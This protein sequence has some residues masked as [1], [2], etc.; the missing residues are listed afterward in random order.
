MSN[1]QAAKVG[2]GLLVIKGTTVLLGKRRGSHGGGEYGGPGGH[3]EYGETCA[4]TA[5]R[6]LEEECGGE[7]K[8][9]NLRMLCVT[10]ILKYPPKHYVDVGFVA[11]W[12]SGDP[13]IVEPDKVD[14]WDWYE[15]DDLPTP[16]FGADPNYFDSLK[17]GQIY[18]QDC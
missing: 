1:E 13:Q 12:V 7:I 6:E 4:Q 10:D 11:D 9:K 15:L 18:Y 8:I 2:V 14:S 3:L 17:S 16:L 5:L